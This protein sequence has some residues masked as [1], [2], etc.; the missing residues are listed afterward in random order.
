MEAIGLLRALECDGVFDDAW[1]AEIIDAAADRQHEQV[2][3]DASR[4]HDF[5]AVLIVHGADQYLFGV[6]IEPHHFTVPVT[7][8]MPVRL[9]EVVEFV[10]VEIDGSRRELVQMWLPEVGS[11]ALD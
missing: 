11:P 2:V 1:G 9:R 5:I 10:D 8:P 7:E 3:I 6:A 4:R